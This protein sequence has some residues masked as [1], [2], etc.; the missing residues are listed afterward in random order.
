MNEIRLITEPVIDYTAIESVH[1]EVK[2]S[3]EEVNVGAL[4]AT[5]DNLAFLK[6]LRAEKN[7]QFAELEDVRKKIKNL[8]NDPYTKFEDAYKA[9]ISA[10]FQSFDKVLQDKI[11]SVEEGI[12]EAKRIELIEY[13]DTLITPEIDFVKFEDA[14]IKI[15]MND[16]KKS[17][18]TQVEAFVTKTLDDYKLIMIQEHSERILVRYKQ[19][20]NASSAI[21]SVLDEVKQ[22]AI[23]KSPKVENVVQA[24]EKAPEIEVQAEAVQS[25]QIFTSSF[26]VK[27]T[28]AQ[29]IALKQY[30][31]NSGLTLE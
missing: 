16:S 2:R 23:L 8:V 24:E 20:R 10:L 27:G 7:K 13:F 19:T 29:L 25:E 31:V 4:V 21:T 11:K 18:R 26:R 12:K 22:E 9:K 5:E 30:I 17:L 15:G 14:N 6:K 28:K 3:L 1:E